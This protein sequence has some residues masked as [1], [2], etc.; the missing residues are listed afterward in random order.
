MPNLHKCSKLTYI[1][2]SYIHS[3]TET[4]C[5]NHSIYKATMFSHIITLHYSLKYMLTKT[6][7]WVPVIKAMVCNNK[8]TNCSCPI[9]T[10]CCM[11]CVTM[12]ALLVLCQ[13]RKIIN[14]NVRGKTQATTKIKIDVVDIDVSMKAI[15]EVKWWHFLHWFLNRP[16]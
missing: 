15:T 10:H 9:K 7:T 13:K 8:M 3:L 4:H 5:S 14:K 16:L 2:H 11:Q 6:P 12:S 1:K